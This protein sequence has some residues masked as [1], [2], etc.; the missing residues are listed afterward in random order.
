MKTKILLVVFILISCYDKK[1]KKVIVKGSQQKEY[2]KSENCSENFDK[3]FEKFARDSIYQKKHVKYPL[4]SYFYKDLM[5]DDLSIEIIKNES[6]FKY[7]DFTMDYL[8]MNNEY[9][10]FSVEKIQSKNII[11]YKRIGY[12]NGINI[13]FKFHFIEQCWFLVSIK[14][15]ST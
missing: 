12:D 15:L 7:I 13:A 10:K 14:N 1:E 11:I 5:S 9:G 8:A 4:K 2:P 3:F 6:S